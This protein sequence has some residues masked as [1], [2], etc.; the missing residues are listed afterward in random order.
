MEEVA[1]KILGHLASL[2]MKYIQKKRP[3]DINIETINWCP[4]K[5]RFCCNRLYDRKPKTMSIKLF[6]KICKD[7]YTIGG[8]VIGIGSMQ[9]DFL[10]DPLLMQ[11][12]EIL[13]RYK[14]KLY[15]YSTTPLISLKKYNDDEVEKILSTFNLLQI[16]VEGITAKDYKEMA[17]IDAFEVLQEQINRVYKII[18][19]KHL[20]IMVHLYFRTYDLNKLR[21][22]AYYKKLTG[23]FVERDAKQIFF[24][25]FGSIKQEDLPKGAKL[26]KKNNENKRENCNGANIS[27]AVI[28]DGRVLGCGCIDWNATVVVGDMK[29]Q[30]ILEVW[31]GEESV[32]F[33]K[34]FERGKIPFICKECG[35]YAPEKNVFKLARFMTYKLTDGLFY[36]ALP[37][38]SLYRRE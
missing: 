11:R 26:Y 22:D 28:P 35:L 32:N 38:F 37:F 34:S 13:N 30:S 29:K 15:I 19:K 36:N 7:Y 33:R 6:H 5:C 24:S 21:K 8:G 14:K 12:L 20:N 9:S 4:M 1:D 17:G 16:S 10:A 18:K 23:M 2:R 25:W 31:Q 27:L 3:I